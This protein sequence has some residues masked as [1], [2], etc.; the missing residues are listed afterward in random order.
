LVAIT[1]EEPRTT[2]LANAARAPKALAIIFLMSPSR[3]VSE[4]RDKTPEEGAQQ[5]CGP[6]TTDFRDPCN[7]LMITLKLI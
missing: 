5:G 4:G 1:E 2:P 7:L 6:L 3:E